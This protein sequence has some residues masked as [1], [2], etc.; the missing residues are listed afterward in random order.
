MISNLIRLAAYAVLAFAAYFVLVT[1]LYFPRDVG[2]VELPPVDDD[3]EARNYYDKIYSVEN[4]GNASGDHEYVIVNR[5][6]TKTTG[7]RESIE[8]FVAE[9][10]LQ[11]ARTLE[12][13]AG[14]GQLQDVVENYT[15]LDIAA[16]AA[17]YFHKPFVQGSA[18]DLP[19]QDSEF[20]VAWT[21]W[22]IEHVPDPERAMVELRRVVKP[23]GMIYFFPAWNCLPW[24]A[25]GY[26]VRPLDTL[27]LPQKLA[28]LSLIVRANP[29]FRW[30]Y[31][32]PIRL[33]RFG[34]LKISDEP[35]RLRYTAIAPNYTVLWE[36]DADAIAS[37]D[38]VEAMFWFTSRGDE[39]L[40]CP[41]SMGGVLGMRNMPLF[42]RVNK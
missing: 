18:T 10:G 13:G 42:I 5:N 22:T 38:S 16:S 12:V 23:G 9:Y 25:T 37:I 24:A 35:T 11:D 8:G 14:S 29:R 2:L 33:L 21:V 7:L 27:T 41:D 30:S 17:R 4:A 6:A 26:A 20:D 36:P 19:F 32:I 28:K 31:R 34:Y 39:C 15:G 40:N 3:V 1:L